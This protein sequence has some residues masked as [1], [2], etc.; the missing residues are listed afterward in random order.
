MKKILC[1]SF[2]FI[3]IFLSTVSAVRIADNIKFTVSPNKTRSLDIIL[4]DDFDLIPQTTDYF[5]TLF[6]NWTGVDL[7]EQTVT[8]NIN[9]T[10][11]IPINFPG[12]R[13]QEGYCS[14]YTITI[15]TSQ[16]AKQWE[17]KVCVSKYNDVDTTIEERTDSFDIGFY[18]KYIF[19]KPGEEKNLTLFVLSSLNTTIELFVKDTGLN[20]KP[21]STSFPVF[22]NRRKTIN[23]T[24]KPPEKSGTYPI[25]VTGKI[26]NCNEVSC[27]KQATTYLKIGNKPNASFTVD[28]FPTNLDTKA[29]EKI[30]YMLTIHNYGQDAFFS[31]YL[32]LPSGIET[33]FLNK[34]I[35]IPEASEKTINFTL[36]PKKPET[37]YEIKAGAVSKGIDKYV[38]ACI[39]TD[40]MVTDLL[41]GMEAIENG[42]GKQEMKEKFNKWYSDYNKTGYMNSLKEYSDLNDLIQKSKTQKPKNQT[43]PNQLPQKTNTQKKETADYLWI[44]LLVSAL[45]GI[46]FVL[47]IVYKFTRKEEDEW[48]YQ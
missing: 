46:L 25:E 16:R 19:S 22:K 30:E 36:I 21:V 12:F 28:I 35:E 29:G 48:E 8:T 11:K 18:K 23:F 42:K 38:T 2:A 15:E 13:K 3:Y 5:I 7:T 1:L 45:A 14:S 44:I 24:V 10:V 32:N 17:G 34:I 40:E 33:T 9:N 31:V 4:P 41:R 20:I 26:R 27:I 37:F 6:T 43:K 47:F 39:T